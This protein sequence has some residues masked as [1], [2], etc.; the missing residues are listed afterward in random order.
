MALSNPNGRQS[1]AAG[2]Y[3]ILM[4]GHMPPKVEECYGHFGDMFEALLKDEPAS[5]HWDTFFVVDDHWPAQGCLETYEGIVVTGS[6]SDS[7]GT[8]PW[9]VRLRDELAAAVRRKQKILGVCFGCQIMAIV[10]GGS[11]GRALVGLEIGTCRI[12]FQ[13]LPDLARGLPWGHALPEDGSIIV[14][15]I[16]QDCVLEL[17]KDATLLA[18][19]PKTRVEVWAYDNHVLCI[20]GHPEFSRDFMDTLIRWRTANA[21]EALPQSQA[22][23]A[24]AQLTDQPVTAT[25]QAALQRLCHAFIA[26]RT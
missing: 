23:Q 10:L 19:S 5:E 18:S 14:H 1:P 3:C 8:D 2:K 24:L 6:A 21:P 26:E 11:A 15:E 16:H 4:C 7:F 9:I 13:Q 20:Q 22:D 12:V 25:D 17:P